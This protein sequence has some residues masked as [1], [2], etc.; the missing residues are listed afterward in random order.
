MM[1]SGNSPGPR[2]LYEALGVTQDASQTVI[3]AVYRQLA[4]ELHPDRNPGFVAEA[5][6]RFKELSAAMRS[7]PI[8]ESAAHTTRAS[9]TAM[10]RLRCRS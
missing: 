9:K 1:M 8:P 10:T 6:A 3:K 4:R 2:T 7:F 5:E